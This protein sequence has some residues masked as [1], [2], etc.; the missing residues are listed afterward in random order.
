MIGAGIH[1]ERQEI[2]FTCA[3]CLVINPHVMDIHSTRGYTFQPVSNLKDFAEARPLT[4][5]EIQVIFSDDI[6]SLATCIDIINHLISG[7]EQCKF[8]FQICRRALSD[9]L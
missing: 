6:M 8:R 7:F 3:Q 9:A 1:L 5:D 2:F 4:V